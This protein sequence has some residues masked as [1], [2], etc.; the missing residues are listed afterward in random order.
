M[1]K[2]QKKPLSLDH[3]RKREQY[4]ENQLK[5]ESDPLIKLD[6]IQ[7]LTNNKELIRDHHLVNILPRKRLS[8]RR[9]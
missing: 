6:L 4:L 2:T 8:L 5:S 1:A 9:K 7:A 3:L